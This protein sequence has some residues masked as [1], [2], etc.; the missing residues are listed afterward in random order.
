MQ[1]LR[2]WPLYW[3]AYASSCSQ[4]TPGFIVEEEVIFA[5]EFSIFLLKN[6]FFQKTALLR[7][8]QS[9]WK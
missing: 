6:T 7:I 5:I 9:H 8:H 1:P 2:A 4:Y 3:I